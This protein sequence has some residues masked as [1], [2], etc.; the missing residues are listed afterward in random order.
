MKRSTG[1]SLVG[2]VLICLGA[3]FLLQNF[4]IASFVTGTIWAL[5]FVAGGAV[6]V[7]VSRS[8]GTTGGQS[9]LALPCWAWAR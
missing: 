9:S 5:L 3:L 7:G 4:G 8:T 2:L 6:F 1:S